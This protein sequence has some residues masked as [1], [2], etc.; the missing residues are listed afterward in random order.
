[1]E[2]GLRTSRLHSK[3]CPSGCLATQHTVSLACGSQFNGNGE[4]MIN[5]QFLNWGLDQFSIIFSPLP[6]TF[7]LAAERSKNHSHHSLKRRCFWLVKYCLAESE[8][9]RVWQNPIDVSYHTDLWVKKNKKAQA[10]SPGSP[11]LVSKNAKQAADKP[12][13]TPFSHRPWLEVQ[14]QTNKPMSF[15]VRRITP[16][17]TRHKQPKRPHLTQSIQNTHTHIPHSPHL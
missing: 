8:H 10:K 1:M 9:R 12:P 14:E 7:W 5:I 11:T 6:T 13:P 4:A 3:L 17:K 15:I 16:V 2:D